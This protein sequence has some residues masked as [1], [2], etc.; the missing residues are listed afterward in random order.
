MDTKVSKLLEMRRKE[1]QDG[2]VKDECERIASQADIDSI[3][4]AALDC[5]QGRCYTR[6]EIAQ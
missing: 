5:D 4:A 3:S 1:I 6:G 2:R